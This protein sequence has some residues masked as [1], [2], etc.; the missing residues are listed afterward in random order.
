MLGSGISC[1]LSQKGMG[2]ESWP[3]SDTWLLYDRALFRINSSP[4][5]SA[6]VATEP[7]ALPELRPP[8]VSSVRAL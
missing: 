4:T 6:R 8:P 2:W 5:W 1:A 7:L 3:G